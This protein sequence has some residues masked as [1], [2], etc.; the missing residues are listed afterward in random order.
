MTEET[1]KTY[2]PAKTDTDK[3]FSQTIR[4]IERSDK[5]QRK[6]TPD[7]MELGAW[8]EK[9]DHRIPAIPMFNW[10]G[11]CTIKRHSKFGKDYI[12]LI[13]NEDEEKFLKV[14]Y[15]YQ[16]L[17]DNR[18]GTAIMKYFR[19]F[20]VFIRRRGG[21]VWQYPPYQKHDTNPMDVTKII[22]ETAENFGMGF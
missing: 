12:E 10:I 20:G 6:M 17:G 4:E 1:K 22:S 15:L 16:W 18:V 14:G 19:V 8:G 11:Q 2:N 5:T 21:V 7:M 13:F 9:N 3:G